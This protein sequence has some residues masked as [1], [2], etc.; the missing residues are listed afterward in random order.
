M[1]AFPFLGT[2]DIG[3]L[4]PLLIVPLGIIAY[5]T[6]NTVAA[7]IAVTAI[8]AIVGNLEKFAVFLFFQAIIAMYTQSILSTILRIQS[9]LTHPVR[10]I[11]ITSS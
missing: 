8:I 2:I 11:F 9:S 10:N 4:Y 6:G 1:F 5:S 7:V 3:L